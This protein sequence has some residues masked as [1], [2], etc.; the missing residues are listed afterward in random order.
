MGY[1]IEGDYGDGWVIYYDPAT[2]FVGLN[3]PNGGK[4][5]VCEC[6]PVR[7]KQIVKALTKPP[8]DQERCFQHDIAFNKGY[9]DGLQD[10]LKEKRPVVE[11]IE[12][13][14]LELRSVCEE[15][16]DCAI[17]KAATKYLKL[18]GEK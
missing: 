15:D 6:N 10:G 9:N 3:H 5:T 11:P 18:T 7:G 17:I 4:Q 14:E 16:K 13:L 2:K 1:E 8:T 12:G